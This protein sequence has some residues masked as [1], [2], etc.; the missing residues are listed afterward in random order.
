MPDYKFTLEEAEKRRIA[1]SEDLEALIS[2]HRSLTDYIC[3]F[4]IT[5]SKRDKNGNI[6]VKVLLD[7]VK[8]LV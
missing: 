4:E 2:R 6:E 7:R 5:G 3:L 8:N 1:F